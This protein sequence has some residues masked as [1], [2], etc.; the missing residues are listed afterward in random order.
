M[1]GFKTVRFVKLLGEEVN[2]GEWV[3]MILEQCN[4]GNLMLLNLGISFTASKSTK[5]KEIIKYMYCAKISSWYSEKFTSRDEA[6]EAVEKLKVYDSSKLMELIWL[7]TAFG[8]NFEESGW[9]GRNP[10]ALHLWI[11]K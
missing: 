9:V 11:Q 5:R 10:I 7:K 3:K 1:I 4:F 8:E 6:Y 2:I